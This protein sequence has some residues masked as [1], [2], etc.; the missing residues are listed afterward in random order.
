MNLLE[1]LRRSLC[2][3]GCHSSHDS[4]NEVPAF[5]G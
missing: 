5:P 1:E 2:V 3:G 4:G